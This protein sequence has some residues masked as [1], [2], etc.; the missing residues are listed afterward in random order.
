MRLVDWRRIFFPSL[1]A[2]QRWEQ[3]RPKGLLR[4]ILLKGVLTFSVLMYVA[5]SVLFY[6]TGWGVVPL[7]FRG[8]DN[9]LETVALF[10]VAGTLWGVLVW[11]SCEIPYASHLRKPI[12]F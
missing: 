10:A 8:R 12:R 5:T 9:E 6:L 1:R 7:T 4:F 11:L 3:E 2:L